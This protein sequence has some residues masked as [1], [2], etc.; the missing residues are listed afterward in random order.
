[1]RKVPM[2]KLIFCLSLTLPTPVLAESTPV[3]GSADARIRS[4]VYNQNNVV[5]VDASYGISTMIVL[6]ESEHIETIAV[7][8]S[9]AWKVEP[10]KRGNIIFLKPV[11]PKAATNMNVVTDKRLYTFVLRSHDAP[12]RTQIYK[13]QFRYPG[14]D[15]DA[16]LQA[17]AEALV[18]DPNRR[19]FN[20]KNANT[21]YGFKGAE[22]LKPVAIFDDG[23]KTWFQFQGEI[24]AIFIVD[25]DRNESL[26]N[27]RREGNFVVVDK[28]SRQWTLRSGD[29]ATCVFNLRPSTPDPTGMEPYAPTNLGTK[30]Q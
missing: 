9:V 1:M 14:E 17:Q 13:I 21:D 30:R 15:Y 5:A 18:N 28:I 24:P 25:N 29:V 7:G 11:A 16:R 12:L 26:A 20:V 19:A 22:T 2:R 10:N 3:P 27:Y 23:T 8:D 4:V 6:G